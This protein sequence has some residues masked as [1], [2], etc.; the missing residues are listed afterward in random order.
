MP[1]VIGWSY[2][3]MDSGQSVPDRIRDRALE[4]EETRGN[5]WRV[6]HPEPDYAS[7]LRKTVTRTGKS[8]PEAASRPLEL[9]DDI[10]PSQPRIDAGCFNYIAPGS[11]TDGSTGRSGSRARGIA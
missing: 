9:P 10:A 6:D 8:G 1:G 4:R 5:Y 3:G 11:L 7:Q 2:R